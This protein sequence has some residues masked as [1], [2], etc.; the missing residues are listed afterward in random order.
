MSVT[1]KLF[2]EMYSIHGC[3]RTKKLPLVYSLLSNKNQET[4]EE[5]FIMVIDGKNHPYSLYYFIP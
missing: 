4:H 1:P 3:V 2:V 5:L